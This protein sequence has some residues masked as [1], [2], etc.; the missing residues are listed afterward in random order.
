MVGATRDDGSFDRVAERVAEELASL[1]PLLSSADQ[2]LMGALDTSR[3][4][5]L[6]QVNSL[7]KKY[8]NAATRRDELI[9]RHLDAVCNSLYPEKKPQERLLNI[10]SFIAR[11]GIGV[12]PRLL[13][14]LSLDSREHQVVEI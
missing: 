5:M 7:R 12:I 14:S 3:R 1:V 4:K 11:Y 10:S 2:T 6:H 13:D 8:V 9:Q